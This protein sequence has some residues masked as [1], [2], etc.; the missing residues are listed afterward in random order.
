MWRDCCS[1]LGGNHANRRL[2]STTKRPNLPDL[3]VGAHGAPRAQPMTRFFFLLIILTSLSTLAFGQA[4]T[5]FEVTAGY[6]YNVQ[7]GSVLANWTN[8]W[9]VGSG[10]S[11]SLSSETDLLWDVR[12][13]RLPYEG[14]AVVLAVPEVTGLNWS[15]SGKP[16]N[17]YESSAGIRFANHGANLR[18]FLALHAGVIATNVGRITVSTWMESQPE[19]VSSETYNG[20]GTAFIRAFGSVGLGVLLAVSPGFDVVAEARFVT[21]ISADEM[22]VPLTLT[23]QWGL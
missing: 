4:E 21:L 2:G 14:G 19:I 8:G 7:G 23:C 17:I 11:C 16:T 12:C 22:F 6:L 1:E 5:R 9:T 3:R 18:P 15:V 10:I 13:S 20:T